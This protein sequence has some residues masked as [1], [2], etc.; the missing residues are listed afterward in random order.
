M[1]NSPRTYGLGKGRTVPGTFPGPD[2]DPRV[3][4]ANKT[5]PREQEQAGVEERRGE[6]RPCRARA[7]QPAQPSGGIHATLPRN[8]CEQQN[9]AEHG[10]GP[11]AALVLLPLRRVASPRVGA[12]VERPRS[13]QPAQRSVPIRTYPQIILSF[14]PKWG[15]TGS[16]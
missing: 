10:L 7:P 13:S 14:C 16:S 3:C 8:D 4:P 9:V 1:F 12:L 5:S 6:E 15:R 2:P 11:L